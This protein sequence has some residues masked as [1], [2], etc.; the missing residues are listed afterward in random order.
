M[1]PDFEAFSDELVKIAEETRE[2]NRAMLKQ[3]AKNLVV[4][5]SGMFVGTALGKALRPL[6]RKAVPSLAKHD[7]VLATGMGAVAGIGA[8]AMSSA[9]SHAKELENKAAEKWRD[10]HGG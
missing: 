1:T 9:I 6:I 2:V 5:G 7:Q 10:E 4:G 8:L 3:L